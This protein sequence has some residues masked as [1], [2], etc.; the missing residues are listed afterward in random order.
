[1]PITSSA[2]KALRQNKKRHKTNSA[3]LVALKKVIK[4]YRKVLA[5]KKVDEAKKLLPGVYRTLDK[6]VKM[7]LIKKGTAN[8]LKS[9]LT[10]KIVVSK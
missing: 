4:N 1:M 8:R 5:S 2:K 6:S 7:N 10:K 3:K 9:R